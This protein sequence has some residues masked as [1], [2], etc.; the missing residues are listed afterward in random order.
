MFH[1]DHTQ[2]SVQAMQLCAV[3]S[4]IQELI[5]YK[6]FTPFEHKYSC[7]QSFKE[8]QPRNIFSA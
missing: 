5:W 2:A 8:T 6:Y 7:Q 3:M 1:L 4:K